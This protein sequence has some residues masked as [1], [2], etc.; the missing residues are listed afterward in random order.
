[1]QWCGCSTQARERHALFDWPA[2][3]EEKR[4]RAVSLRTFFGNM[5]GNL[6]MKASKGGANEKDNDVEA[7]VDM[8]FQNV[9]FH[10]MQSQN[11]WSSFFSNSLL[12]SVRLSEW[13]D[14]SYID[15][16]EEVPYDD[17]IS[18]S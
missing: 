6:L 3:L 10:A 16:I 8:C 13:T 12:I 14:V 5:T 9:S 18:D 11:H 17:S 1:M 4:V 7:A 2:Q 15:S